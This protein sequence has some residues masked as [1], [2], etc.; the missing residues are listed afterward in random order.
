[1]LWLSA[2]IKMSISSKSGHS[3]FVLSTSIYKQQSKLWPALGKTSIV[4]IISYTKLRCDAI[5][6]DH[7]PD[8]VKFPDNNP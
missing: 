6:G 4:V 8:N 5:Q 3:T 1:M 2:G 7:S